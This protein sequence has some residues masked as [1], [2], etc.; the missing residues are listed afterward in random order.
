[1]DGKEQFIVST[2]DL[3]RIFGVKRNAVSVWHKNGCPRISRGTW[4]LPEVIEWRMEGKTTISPDAEDPALLRARKLQ[5]DTEYREERAQRERLLREILEDMYFKRSDVEEAWANRALE[6]KMAFLIFEKTLP[7]ELYGKEI[8]EMESIIA[9]R[10]REV[11]SNY[12]RKGRYCGDSA[13]SPERGDSVDAAGKT[14]S[15]RV[16]RPKSRP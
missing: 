13:H 15:P 3:C 7:V 5:A 14:K 4:N 6:A 2:T 9:S 12:A 11:L 10:V 8:E 16:G 1:M